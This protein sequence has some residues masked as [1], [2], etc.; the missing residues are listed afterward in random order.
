LFGVQNSSEAERLFWL[1]WMH[2]LAQDSLSAWGAGQR[3]LESLWALGA[4][5][6]KKP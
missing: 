6:E 1:P 2:F 4:C 5:V 3:A